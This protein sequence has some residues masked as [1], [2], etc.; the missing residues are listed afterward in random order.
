MDRKAV[1]IPVADGEYSLQLFNPFAPN[2][3]FL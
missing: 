2:A 1:G 3:P